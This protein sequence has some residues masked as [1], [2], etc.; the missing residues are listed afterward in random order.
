M[1]IPDP[2]TPP[3]PGVSPQ[4]PEPNPEANSPELTDWD[5]KNFPWPFF[6]VNWEDS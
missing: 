3:D 1:F 4:P 6:D 5:I 2:V